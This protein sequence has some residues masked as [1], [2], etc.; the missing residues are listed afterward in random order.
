[1]SKPPV[2]SKLIKYYVATVIHELVRIKVQG[3]SFITLIV[4]NFELV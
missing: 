2:L 1:M 3:K 4:A